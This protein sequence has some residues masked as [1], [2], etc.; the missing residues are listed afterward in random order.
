MKD[1]MDGLTVKGAEK[2]LA[3]RDSWESRSFD[4]YKGLGVQVFAEM[5]GD[6]K[7]RKLVMKQ[8]RLPKGLRKAGA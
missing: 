6:A 4:C 5:I 7:F 3:W 8:L 1:H 2:L